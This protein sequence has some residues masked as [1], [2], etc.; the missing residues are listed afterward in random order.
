MS[1]P[2]GDERCT[3]QT[4]RASPHWRPDAVFSAVTRL[5]SEL[6]SG[7]LTAVVTIAAPVFSSLLSGTS[8]DHIFGLAALVNDM[9]DFA[10]RHLRYR[11]YGGVRHD[12]FRS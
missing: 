7:C 1:S 12:V 8:S 5:V 2:V 10:V 4:V 3:N 11:S 9:N 6:P